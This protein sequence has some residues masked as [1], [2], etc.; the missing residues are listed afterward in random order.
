MVEEG[1]YQAIDNFGI[2]GIALILSDKH[3]EMV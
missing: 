2:K 3:K 1:I